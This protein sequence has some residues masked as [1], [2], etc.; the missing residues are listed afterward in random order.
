MDRRDAEDWEMARRGTVFNVCGEV[1]DQRHFPLFVPRGT[2]G[3]LFLR[4]PIF[5][6]SA[7]LGINSRSEPKGWDGADAAGEKILMPSLATHETGMAVSEEA[8]NARR[9]LSVALGSIQVRT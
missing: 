8:A 3:F 7:H 4:A 5:P 2:E 6:F 1:T 9:A